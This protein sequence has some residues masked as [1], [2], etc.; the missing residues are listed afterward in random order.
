MKIL[1]DIWK[2]FQKPIILLAAFILV[3]LVVLKIVP[4]IKE[5]AA[6][7]SPVTKIIV[8][9]NNTYAQGEE[10]AAGDFEVIAVHKNGA[11]TAIDTDKV[12]LSKTTPDPTG[13]I[14]EVK[15]S[16][17]G[18]SCRV[19]V[20]NER[21]KIVTFEC[22][23]PDVSAVKA[24]LYSNGELSFEGV[25]DILAFTNAEFPWKSYE[26][27]DDYPVK[28][29]TFEE[30]VTPS[31]MDG[32]FTGMETLCY[33]KNI[34]DTVES[35]VNTFSGCAA[36]TSSPDLTGCNSL[37]DLTE[38]FSDCI[39]L[40]TTSPIPDTVKN[41]TG[42]FS[43]CTSLKTGADVSNASGV[44]NADSIY[45][46]CI[47]LNDAKLPPAVQSVESAFENCINLKSMPEIPETVDYMPSCFAG[48]I[49]LT[50]LG[51]IPQGVLDVGNAFDGCTKIRGI[52]TV[53]CNPE[54]YNGFLNDTASATSLDLQGDS[55]VLDVLAATSGQN[56]NITVNGKTPD[57][58]A[59][60]NEIMEA[61]AKTDANAETGNKDKAEPQE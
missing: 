29:V 44:T 10:I 37:Y 28:A 38:T 49:S 21:N 11:K 16:A 15:V 24:V 17:E 30:T 18:Q 12:K 2:I 9:N 23:N 33:V 56:E 34:P 1:K 31:S 58:E 4:A 5:S 57:W 43:G 3:L 8:T 40:E 55:L 27:D 47:V 52:L 35:M 22:G 6:E 53:N 42:T 50:T 48:D 26:G 39:S 59:D 41:M 61:D 54:N 51:V 13:S 20:K 60:Y 45:A 46:D 36:L 19:K 7:D 25:G 32:Y 14:T